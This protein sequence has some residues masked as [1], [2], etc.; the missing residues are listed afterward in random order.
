MTV[1]IDTNVM[2]GMFVTG[3]P[4]AAIR[5]AI[6]ASADYLI[7]SDKHFNVLI[8]SGYKPQPVTPEEFITRFLTTA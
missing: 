5:R 3:H 2:N 1:V 4:H 8:G 7:T 6:A